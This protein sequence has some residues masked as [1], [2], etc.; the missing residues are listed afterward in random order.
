[1][2][3]GG[4]NLSVARYNDLRA[5]G[6]SIPVVSSSDSHGTVG[7]PR[8]NENYTIL[9]AEENNSDAILKAIKSGHSAAVETIRG[10][11]GSEYKAYGSYRLVSYTRYLIDCYFSQYAE[12]CSAEGGFIRDYLLGYENS[13]DMIKICAA[14]AQT[15]YKRFFGKL[16][17]VKPTVRAQRSTEKWE[18]I[19]VYRRR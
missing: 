12:V 5:K 9:F 16:P 13:S 2:E 1:M 3:N 19:W 4:N 10:T 6:L 7:Y 17:A 15:F 14:R 8:F 11:D 18:K